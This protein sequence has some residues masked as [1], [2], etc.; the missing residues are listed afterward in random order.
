M[1]KRPNRRTPPNAAERR[2][3]SLRRRRYTKSRRVSKPPNAVRDRSDAAI[4]PNRD[5]FL[6]PPNSRRDYFFQ[7]AFSPTCFPQRVFPLAPRL[8]ALAEP[9][10]TPLFPFPSQSSNSP[11]FSRRPHFSQHAVVPPSLPSRT[12]KNFA[13][14]QKFLK[15]NAKTIKKRQNG[16]YT[17]RKNRQN[18][19][20]DETR[21]APFGRVRQFRVPFLPTLRRRFAVDV[22]Q[23]RRDP[24][25]LTNKIRRPRPSDVFR[26][27]PR[28]ALD[29]RHIQENPK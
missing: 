25:F 5:A 15:K 24:R 6:K 19:P 22:R 23:N 7:N 18:P 20:N 14:G 27:R 3:R 28:P 16:L 1:S 4:I 29:D 17:N 2:P 9:S 26:L 8:D 13:F 11:Y 12:R 10:P 21:R